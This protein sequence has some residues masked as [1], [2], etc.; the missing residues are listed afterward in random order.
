MMEAKD[1]KNGGV[2]GI[3]LGA[4]AIALAGIT[5]TVGLLRHIGDM[6][7]RVGDIVCFEPL[8]PMSRDLRTQITVSRAGDRGGAACVMDVRVMHAA[9]GSVVVEARR[10]ET[11][12]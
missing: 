4:A 1:S 9:G 8:D 7:P 5:G 2:S 10:L 12:R 6:G 3:L 11:P